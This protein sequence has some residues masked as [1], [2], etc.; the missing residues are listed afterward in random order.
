[1][2]ITKGDT[3]AHRL[4]LALAIIDCIFIIPGIVIYW[5]KAFDWQAEWYNRL[6][7]YV[8]YPLSEIALCSSIYMTVA[9]AVER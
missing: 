3:F 5:A 8:F 4:L 2:W 9:I 7:P 1:M 6:F